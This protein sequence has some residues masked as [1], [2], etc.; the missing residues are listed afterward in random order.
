MASVSDLLISTWLWTQ[1]KHIHLCNGKR[2]KYKMSS[3]CSE[4]ICKLFCTLVLSIQTILHIMAWYFFL[5]VTTI[6]L[7]LYVCV[8]QEKR[9]PNMP[10][11]IRTVPHKW[12]LASIYKIAP[13]DA[14]MLCS[15][16]HQE[17]AHSLSSCYPSQMSSR[18]LIRPESS[19]CVL[20]LH[21]ITTLSSQSAVLGSHT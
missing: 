14:A 2:K 13:A 6:S 20:F 15:E 9:Y 8:F 10:R 11:L 3:E 12:T 7:F 17:P 21:T 19:A 4:V 18:G 16:W 1:W 5:T